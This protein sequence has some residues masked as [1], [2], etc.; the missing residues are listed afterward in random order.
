MVSI[1]ILQV[2]KSRYL[3]VSELYSKRDHGRTW[4]SSAWVSKTVF[5]L[6]VSLWGMEMR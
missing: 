3:E 4:D 1:P 6:S 5:A 2:R